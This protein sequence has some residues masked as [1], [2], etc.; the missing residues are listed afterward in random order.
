MACKNDPSRFFNPFIALLSISDVGRCHEV[1][2]LALL[3]ND[4]VF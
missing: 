2:L 4:C 3:A 1:D